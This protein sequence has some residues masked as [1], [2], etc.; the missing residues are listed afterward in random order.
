VPRLTEFREGPMQRVLSKD[1]WTEIKDHACASKSRKAAIAYVTQDLVGFREGDTLVVDASAAAIKNGETHAPLLQ[2]L[3]KKGVQLYDC[4]NLHAKTL[5]LDDVAIISSGNMSTS[6]QTRMVEAALITDHA[7][8]VAGVA[9]LIEQLKK[10]SKQLDGRQ[11]AQLRK[12]KVTRRNGWNGGRLERHKPRI[13]E[14]G[15]RTWIV[16]VEEIIPSPE[17]E[18]V[19]GRAKR[20]L[21]QQ[22]NIADD[23]FNWIK[24]TRRDR[25]ARECREGDLLIWIWSSHSAKRPSV[26]IKP[27]PVLL[28]QT[29]PWAAFCLSE[30]SGRSSKMTWGRFQRLLKEVR[31]PR[32]IKAGSVQLVDDHIA[33]TISRKWNSAARA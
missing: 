3:H 15:N 13:A 33:E 20:S 23:D 2:R 1:L 12:I 22:L 28:K 14:L 8:V 30:P 5:L 26:V 21:Q 16:D 11:I 10:Q 9:S 32:R 18:R 29:K 17:E 24:W 31:Y 27:V 7:S 6:S 19:I 25:F 4:A